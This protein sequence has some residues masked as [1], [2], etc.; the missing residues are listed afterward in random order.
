VAG[1]LPSLHNLLNPENLHLQH[2][3]HPPKLPP[4]VPLPRHSLPT[5]FMYRHDKTTVL[6]PFRPQQVPVDPAKHLPALQEPAKKD[7]T[8]HRPRISLYRWL[9][10]HVQDE[11]DQQRKV[12][13]KP[14]GDNAPEKDAPPKEN[15]D[16]IENVIQ[17]LL[18][19][20]ISSDET[21]EYER[22]PH[23]NTSFVCY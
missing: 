5:D 9:G 16:A 21:K 1:I 10:S 15:K 22:Y 17:S 7:E 19:P 3:L 4:Q 23:S 8:R 2:E 14:D 6:S 13:F 12:T 20:K 18:E 11:E